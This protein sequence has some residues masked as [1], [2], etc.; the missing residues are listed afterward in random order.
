MTRLLKRL[1][2]QPN[3]YFALID[4]QG[5][6]RALCQAYAPPVHGR[7]IETTRSQAHWINQRLTPEQQQSAQIDNKKAA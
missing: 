6:C 1:F 4:E 7:W 3:R 5:I 2:S